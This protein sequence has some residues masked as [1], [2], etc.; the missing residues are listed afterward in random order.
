M[1]VQDTLWQ[2]C[3]GDWQPLFIRDYWLPLGHLAWQGWLH[4]GPGMVVC[5][6]H[7]PTAT[8]D[9]SCTAVPY[10]ARFVPQADLATCW[11][12]LGLAADQQPVVET[13]VVTY[14]PEQ[15]AI[16]L[17]LGDSPPHL[18]CLKGWA[19]PPP[20]CSRQMGHRSAEFTVTSSL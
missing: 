10:T 3:F 6:I 14:D 1:R 7:I 18:S 5:E 8:V 13:A 20:E 11:G 17:L 9:W 19:V 15:D 2:G 16:L 4:H 12:D